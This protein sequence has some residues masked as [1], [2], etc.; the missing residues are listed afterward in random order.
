MTESV[1]A[2][3]PAHVMM[4][5]QGDAPIPAGMRLMTDAER[6]E[7]SSLVYEALSKQVDL[8]ELLLVFLSSYKIRRA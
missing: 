5:E 7:H 8:L 4:A 6:F 2:V 3:G 1:P